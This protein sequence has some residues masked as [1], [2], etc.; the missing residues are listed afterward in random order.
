MQ[1]H[2]ELIFDVPQEELKEVVE[3]VQRN[4]EQSFKLKVP[5][6]V[7]VKYAKNWGDIKGYE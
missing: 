6:K 3:I 4:M 2:D 7:N 1:I 5:L